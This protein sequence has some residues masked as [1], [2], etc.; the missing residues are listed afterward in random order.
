M[1][2]VSAL[3]DALNEKFAGRI[4][5]SDDQKAIIA[6][7]DD[8]FNVL[9][10]LKENKDFS[11]LADLTAVDYTDR[12]E[13]VYHLMNLNNGQIL[14]VKANLGKDEPKIDSAYPLWKSANVMERETWDLMGIVFEGHPGLKRILCPDDFE[15][16]PLRKDFKVEPA[17]RQ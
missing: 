16:H 5:M 6:A 4:S 13:V 17:V 7:A 3:V 12:F 2:N 8:I 11:F 15:G 14:R 9:K 10:E 1:D